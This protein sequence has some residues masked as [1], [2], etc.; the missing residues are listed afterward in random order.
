MPDPI[1]PP[2]TGPTEP[3]VTPPPE[4]V[5]ASPE[6]PT[7]IP[8]EKPEPVAAYK[9]DPRNEIYK[10]ARGTLTLEKRESDELFA[11]RVARR[12][13]DDGEPPP[14]TPEPT[15]A[16]LA[17]ADG[18]KAVKI[19]VYGEE[20]E[21]P[22]AEVMRAGVAT[23]QK[24]AAADQKLTDVGRR[25][26]ALHQEEQRLLTIA[27][28]LRMGLDEN[29]R[30][31]AAPKPPATADAPGDRTIDDTDLSK[32]VV[33][34]LY[35]GDAEKATAALSGV[36]KAIS[37]RAGTADPVKPEI[38]TSIADAVLANVNQRQAADAA[39]RDLDEANRIFREDFK[40]IS[41]DPDALAMA[42][43]L[44]GQLLQDPEWSKKSRAEIAKEVGSRVRAKIAPA[45]L[46]KT[47]EERRD[48]KRALPST[49]S[50]TARQPAPQPQRFP[51]NSE[52]IERLRRNSGSNSAPR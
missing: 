50:S 26:A 12:A 27:A 13:A 39:Q 41:S 51:S 7:E 18:T 19:K 22:V 10:R 48:G 42:R 11:D 43:G 6:P 47:L 21:V 36:L 1:E 5:A 52:Y 28:N 25:E 8:P 29:G 31:I 17:L 24:D 45:T 35:S 23:L 38:V 40:D 9:T 49:P 3:N 33:E 14:E 20:R 30:P 32:G 46:A 15:A 37:S 4:P 2:D 34:A 16:E 44:S